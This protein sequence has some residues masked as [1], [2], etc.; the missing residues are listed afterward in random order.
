MAQ[1]DEDV[2]RR[3]HQ[4]GDRLVAQRLGRNLTQLD[5]AR[6]AATS[7]STVRR[8]EAGENVSIEALIRILDALQLGDR[9][10]ALAPP[11]TVRPVERVTLGGNERRRAT[12]RTTK[13][14]PPKW[15]WGD[16]R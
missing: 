9:L 12:A 10:E 7:V 11:A 2:K 8:L 1:S 6:E 5:L 4:L 14:T 16:Q 15:T 3:M 13:R